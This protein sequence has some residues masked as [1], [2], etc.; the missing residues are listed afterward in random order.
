[1]EEWEWLGVPAPL[2]RG[3]ND[4]GFKTPTP[5]Q[6]QAIAATLKSK[7]DIIGAAETVS[8]DLI[9]TIFMDIIHELLTPC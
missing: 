3:L 2:I 9:I 6:K 7:G 4:L 5:I 8:E 1:M